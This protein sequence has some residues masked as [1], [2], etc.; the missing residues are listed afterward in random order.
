LVI[1]ENGELTIHGPEGDNW[2]GLGSHEV[3]GVIDENGDVV[4]SPRYYWPS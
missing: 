2:A 1:G 3:K 4:Q